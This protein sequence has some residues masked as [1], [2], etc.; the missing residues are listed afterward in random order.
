MAR[1]SRL[2]RSIKGKVAIVTG[3]ASGMGRATAQL[4]ADEG[5]HVAVTD[6]NQDRID[7]VVDAIN[8]AGG[9]AS[10]WVLDVTN[11]SQRTTVARAVEERWGG[12]DILVNNAGIAQETNIDGDDFE[13]IWDRTLAVLLTSQA[14]LIRACLPALERS[15]GGR[16]VNIASLAGNEGTPNAPA[17]SAAKAGVIALTKSMGKELAGTGVLVNS[18]AP[19]ALDTEMVDRMDPAHVEVMISKSP[20]KR[21]GTAEECASMVCWL[22]SEECSFSTGAC[23]D[24]SGGR[25]VY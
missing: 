25:T 9:D 23:F 22:L 16:I 17:Y 3:A 12:I 4:F 1:L 24:V 13:A 6:L 8:A 7:L 15:T 5:A 11:A 18:V 2:E 20:L 10:G 19:A 21:L 14:Q